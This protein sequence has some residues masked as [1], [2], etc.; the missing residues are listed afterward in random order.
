MEVYLHWNL[1]ENCFVILE[2][3]EPFAYIDNLLR[4]AKG[5]RSGIFRTALEL[6]IEDKLV[7]QYGALTNDYIISYIHEYHPE[8]LI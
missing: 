5:E 1:E 3:I 4:I 7:I 6:L 8:E 2:E